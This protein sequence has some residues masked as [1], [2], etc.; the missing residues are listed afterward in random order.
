MADEE[1]AYDEPTKLLYLDLFT[2]I[3]IIEHLVRERF[4][5]QHFAD[6]RSVDFAVLNYFVRLGKESEKLQTLAWCF[7]VETVAVRATVTALASRRLVEVDWVDG[8]EC[9][10]VTDAG[11]AKHAEAVAD[12]APDILEIMSEFDPADLRITTETLKEIRRTFDN[13]PDR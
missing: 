5:P 9:V 4:E 13:L 11:R 7:Q 12:V 1:L 6:L 10:F 3:A 2:E 8:F